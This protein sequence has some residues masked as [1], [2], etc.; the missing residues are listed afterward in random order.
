MW[1]ARCHDACVA[2]MEF[3]GDQSQAAGGEGEGD[4]GAFPVA[5]L[6]VRAD[7]RY[8]AVGSFDH[9]VYVADLRQRRRVGGAL[10]GH[11]DRVSRLAAAADGD[12]LLSASFDGDV[13]LWSFGS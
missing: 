8:A 9:C 4:D 11:A 13:R 10:R 1:D 6:A 2:A 5:G 7:G 3:P 12:R